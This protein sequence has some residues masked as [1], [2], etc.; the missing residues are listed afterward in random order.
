ME[1][2]TW[3][4]VPVSPPQFRQ[5]S[6]GVVQSMEELYSPVIFGAEKSLECAC[7]ELKGSDAAGRSC[8]KCR[9][10]VQNDA[11]IWRRRL[12]GRLELGTFV[13]HPLAPELLICEFPVAPIGYRQQDGRP[14]PL[15]L[16]YEAILR[17]VAEFKRG[18]PPIGTEEFFR[19]AAH[20]DASAI[21]AALTNL[22]GVSAHSRSTCDPT[23]LEPGS[24]LF[25][26]TKA[27]ISL[28]SELENLVHS[29]GC[30]LELHA[31]I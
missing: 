30:Q 2:E 4:I 14:T 6:S 22:V 23:S 5:W 31:R 19:T 7:G 11:P 29:C 20:L 9:V 21:Q 13:R 8:M 24:L 26:L 28:D 25:E 3:R 10:R 1:R 15:G 27:L 12:M 17:V 16:R 18:A